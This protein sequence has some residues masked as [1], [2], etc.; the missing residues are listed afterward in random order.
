MQLVV[1]E[2]GKLKIGWPYSR[3]APC[4]VTM[5]V[6]SLGRAYVQEANGR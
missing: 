4:C 3:R 1:P 2:A 5:V 6:A